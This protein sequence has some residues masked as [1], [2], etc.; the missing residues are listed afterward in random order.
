MDQIPPNRQMALQDVSTVV[1]ILPV[2]IDEHKPGLI[3]GQYIL[4]GVKDPLKDWN[5]LHVARAQFP[6]YLD[7]NRPALIV[8]APSDVVAES[9][10]RDY[11]VGI[12]LIE[13][14]VAEP[15][16]FWA[17]GLIKHSDVPVVL[18]KELARARA[19]Q[20]EWFK[21]QIA[22]ADDDWGRYHTRKSISTLQ[23]IAA[24]TLKLEREWN[25]DI[26]VRENL[27]LKTCKFCM[28]D[29]NPEAIVCRY[30]QGILDTVRYNSEFKR[31]TSTV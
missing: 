19:L 12:G 23:K 9:I 17:R 21:R 4:A 1:S 5:T 2:K 18:E 20:V 15:G 26:E 28:A 10:C 13:H 31:A 29:L 7:E 16:L 24:T 30:C 11:K 14:G 8:P 25:I 27:L 3:P 22:E 6:V